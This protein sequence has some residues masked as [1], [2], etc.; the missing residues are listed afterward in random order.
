MKKASNSLNFST[1]CLV[2][3]R[4]A[5]L[6]MKFKALI[7]VRLSMESLPFWPGLFIIEIMLTKMQV[8][9][10][11]N[12]FTNPVL[13]PLL[14]IFCC[15]LWGSAFPAIKVGYAWFHIEGDGS[16]ILFAGYRFFMAGVFTFLVGCLLEKRILTVKLNSVPAICVQGILQT[17]FQ[18]V[19]FYIG[20]ANTTAAKGSIINAINGFVSI[21]AAHFMLRDE[22]MTWKKGVGCLL[23]ML[24][25]V[26]VNLQSGSLGDGFKMTGDGFVLLASISYGISSVTL[27]MISGKESPMAITA[28]QLLFG[29]TLLI[30][31]G[32]ALGGSI[33]G[34]DM[35]STALFL[36]LALLS[37]VT[38]SIWTVLLKY[39][40]VGKVAVYGF[41][42]P[43]FGVI[44]SGLILGEEVLTVKNIL[45][46][47]L[48]SI[49]IFIVNRRQEE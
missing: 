26:V 12:I 31:L 29:S 24:G 34:F 42:I 49:G 21:V 37:T 13:V 41:T 1:S 25:V 6:L 28:Y 43:I 11:E 48:V 30:I 39:N 8:K 44:L 32:K 5:F 45:A 38:F 7:Q 18:Y 10:E 15:I 2:F 47:L 22:K 33:S 16:Q 4:A 9:N 40:P 14:A 36:Y 35:R 46:L 3:Q 20:L 19:F 23:G 27:K 17:A